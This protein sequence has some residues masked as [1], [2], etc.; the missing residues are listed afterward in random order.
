[1][2]KTHPLPSPYPNPHL[3]SRNP[4]RN[5][6]KTPS[7]DSTTSSTPAAIR[8]DSPLTVDDGKSPTCDR[9]HTFD[10]FVPPHKLD[11][12][13]EPKRVGATWD[14]VRAIVKLKRPLRRLREK[15]RRERGG[16]MMR[17]ESS[18]ELM[19]AEEGEE[20]KE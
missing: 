7:S 13:K 10:S 8:H 20:G 18:A 5:P 11:G 6:K 16:G 1:M 12:D 15:R 14:V 9:N 3:A 17:L 4:F 19:A 2:L